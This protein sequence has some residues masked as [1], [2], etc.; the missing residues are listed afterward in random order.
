MMK[1]QEP[2]SKEFVES[3]VGRPKP[4]PKPAPRIEEDEELDLFGP[5]E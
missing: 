4:P 2:M 5:K 1:T 3:F